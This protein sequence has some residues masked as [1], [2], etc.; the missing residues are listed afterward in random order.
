MR[1]V[2]TNRKAFH[3]YQIIDKFEAGIALTG[4]E[5]KAIREGRLS[6]KE[7]Y[8]KIKDGEVLL[9][10]MYIGEYPPAGRKQHETQRT[11]RL[12]L[13]KKEI[14]RLS[15]RVQE[16]GFTLVPLSVYFNDK[17]LVK[18]QLG[19]CRGRRLYDKRERIKE[20][21]ARRLLATAK[22]ER[23]LAKK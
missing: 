11:R 22:A 8:A 13:H 19:L 6:L 15:Q 23:R 2:A 20:R 17:N 3:N 5:V 21:D 18:I 16:K 14:E 1:T 9:I 4:T 10:G 7:S 12:L